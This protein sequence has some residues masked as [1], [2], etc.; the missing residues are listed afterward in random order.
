MTR[1]T[2]GLDREDRIITLLVELNL[3]FHHLEVVAHLRSTWSGF[4]S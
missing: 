3:K 2:K 1:L 4:R